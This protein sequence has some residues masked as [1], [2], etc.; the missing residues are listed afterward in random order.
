MNSNDSREFIYNSKMA[1]FKC[2]QCNSLFTNLEIYIKH[3][4]CLHLLTE[5][6]PC[7]ACSNKY[8]TFPGIRKHMK[9]C[10]LIVSARFY[11][12][13]VV[14]SSLYFSLLLGGMQ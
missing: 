5:N 8:N 7:G 10:K 6:L 12:F 4:R 11:S 13:F 1:H 3:L 14:M 9:K 2:R